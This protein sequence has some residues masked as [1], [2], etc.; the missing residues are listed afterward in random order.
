MVLGVQWHRRHIF[1]F[2]PV[3]D[4]LTPA[5]ASDYRQGIVVRYTAKTPLFTDRS[6]HDTIGD[7]RLE[8]LFLIQMPRHHH[9]DV[10]IDFRRPVT[11]YRFLSDEETAPLA[12]WPLSEIPVNV[13]GKGDTHDRLVEKDF[14]PG[15]VTLAAG[16]P[17]SCSP[18][19]GRF[20]DAPPA[21]LGFE[22]VQ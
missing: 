17:K 21:P 3:R 7:G 19:L 5:D 9:D 6:Y 14:E 8:G 11:V 12:R 4:W 20:K 13:P 18:I 15:R 2:R 16:G 1:P 10:A 22:L